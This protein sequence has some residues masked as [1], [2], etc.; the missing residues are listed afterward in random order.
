MRTNAIMKW[1]GKTHLQLTPTMQKNTP[2]TAN[3][4]SHREIMSALPAKIHRKEL[5]VDEHNDRVKNPR[6]FV[7]IDAFNS[8]GGNV[9][10][11]SLGAGIDTM[12]FSQSNGATI[13][14]NIPK[15]HCERNVC[16]EPATSVV[17]NARRRCRSAGMMR[18]KYDETK[19]FNPIMYCT[20]SRQYLEQRNKTFSQNTYHY[21]RTGLPS[22]VSTP[23]PTDQINR[24]TPGGLLHCPKFHIV[25]PVNPSG[26][27]DGFMEYL[28]I[29]RIFST[30]TDDDAPDYRQPST[31]QIYFK[32]GY[33]TIEDVNQTIHDTMTANKHYFINK[34]TGSKEFLMNVIYNIYTQKIELQC[35]SS[36]LFPA[37]KYDVP[38]YDPADP[39]LWTRPSYTING[40]DYGVCPV[41]YVPTNNMS[42]AIGFANGYYPNVVHWLNDP[43][44]PDF[45]TNKLNMYYP[46]DTRHG[47]GISPN[48]R[49]THYAVLSTLPYQVFPLYK[50]VE[51]NPNNTRFA[52]QGAVSAS[53]RTLR[54]K[55]DQITSNGSSYIEPY[56][57]A[58]S[59]A[60]AYSTRS[61][62]YSQKDT[63][64][65]PN[66][67]TTVFCPNSG[68][69]CVNII[70]TKRNLP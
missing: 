24:F 31:Y 62:S 15:N 55:Y 17:E 57:S 39:L 58:T 68:M 13:D 35:L 25:S 32:T 28:W 54:Q 56:N 3:H 10:V 6:N 7:S 40:T 43:L 14:M 50:S 63:L 18:P 61:S 46:E 16:S 20:N 23:D 53:T 67:K 48:V 49:N 47:Y 2:E 27:N 38:L 64:G 45:D 4:L 59:N 26:N 70:R 5:F 29:N 34:N 65:Y 30:Q 60:L 69:K 51:Y 12:C 22:L 52:Q 37:D 8:P 9:I 19:S 44:N 36:A 33:Y 11:E 21:T 1:K 66:K 42:G 41:L